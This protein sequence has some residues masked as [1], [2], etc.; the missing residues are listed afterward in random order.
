MARGQL[1]QRARRGAGGAEARAARSRDSSHRR[2]DL[3]ADAQVRGSGLGVQQ[4]RQPA[5]EQGQQRQGGLVARRDQVSALVRPEGAV[6]H[7]FRAPTTVPH[8]A[9]S[10]R[11]RQGDHPREGERRVGAGF[12]RRHRVGEHGP[13]APDGGAA[14]GRADHLHAERRRRRSG[15]ARAA[16][17]AHRLVRDRHAEAAQRAVHHQEPRAARPPGARGGELFAARA[18]LLDDDRLQ[19]LPAHDRAAPAGGAGRLRAAAAAVP[20][21]HGARRGRRRSRGRTS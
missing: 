10:P 17:G 14:R 4:L 21:R 20:A 16:A 7:G 5:A 2:G 6:R 18:R 9:V 13:V 3:R 12:H 8:H 1:D 15:A 19:A 11:E